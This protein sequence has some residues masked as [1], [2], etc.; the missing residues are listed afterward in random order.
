MYS[1]WQ[2]TELKLCS[3]K[4]REGKSCL[5]KCAK[6][7]LPKTAPTVIYY[8]TVNSIHINVQDIK[9]LTITLE[10]VSRCQGNNIGVTLR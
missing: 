4:A 3:L 5:A 10:I 2:G 8:T 7:Y 9:L 6:R 1:E